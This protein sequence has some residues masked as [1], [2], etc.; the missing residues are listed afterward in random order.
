MT[1]G[2]GRGPRREADPSA[3]PAR[4]SIDGELDGVYLRDGRPLLHLSDIPP[5]G[6]E[7]KV[8]LFNSRGEAVG[9]AEGGS[10]CIHWH[11]YREETEAIRIDSERASMDRLLESPSASMAIDSISK[12]TYEEQKAVLYALQNGDAVNL[13]YASSQMAKTKMYREKTKH[14]TEV[15]MGRA[16][17]RLYNRG[18]GTVSKRSDGLI[19]LTVSRERLRAVIS[20]EAAA[21]RQ[22]GA[23]DINLMKVPCEIPTS[24]SEGASGQSAGKP[25]RKPQP[26]PSDIPRRVS[27]ERLCA[28]K[29]LTGIR[30]V[31]DAD[32][33]DIELR[34]L[35]YLDDTEDRI[36]TLLDGYTG[37]SVGFEYSTRFNDISKAAANLEKFD[38]ALKQSFRDHRRAVFLTLTTDPNL[39][40]EERTAVRD[41]RL[42]KVSA[43]LSFPAC[44]PKRRAYLAR[45][46][47]QIMG[48]DAEIEELE[49][50]KEAGT[51]TA[52]GERRLGSLLADRKHAEELRAVLADPSTGT[53]T[54]ERI[55]AALKR[56]NR[57][58]YRWD[59]KGFRSVWE[60]NRSFGRSW[61]KFMAY[62]TKK[63]GGRRP[64][65]ISAFEFTE[66]GLLHIHVLI[67]VDYLAD[68]EEISKEWRRIGQGEISYIYGLKAVRSRDGKDWEWRWN[69]KARPEDAK[70][71]SGGDYLKKY[72][73]K[74]ML[75]MMDD[76]TSPARIQSPYW[77]FNKRFNSCSRSLM[78]GF[79]EPGKDK[80]KNKNKNKTEKAKPSR[81]GI[82]RI[83]SAGEAEFLS[84]EVIYHRVTRESMAEHRA[85]DPPD[86]EQAEGDAHDQRS[87][88]Q[89]LPRHPGP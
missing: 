6:L 19:W 25:P 8:E 39:S 29:I 7:E 30:T 9:W 45:K 36:I 13:P 46:Y 82:W 58:E 48:P 49:R 32:R 22:G 64:Q 87:E 75:A 55:I 42:R 52:D 51:I 15:A 57:W 31:G 5:E 53:R 61:N 88:H 27:A 63:R 23:R 37:D 62:L 65:Y 2:S 69:A 66:S 11:R 14:A 43:E 79:G 44:S 73:R 77:A 70:G 59:P 78:K 17:R 10:T 33:S 28:I 71:M 54:K 72:V 67:F 89:G 41:A 76:Y 74:A 18:L 1:R 47:W 80:N 34:F 26:K 40:D 24:S 38:Y 68:A 4:W 35:R 60:A 16:F 84:I 21:R 85:A 12:L 81:W 3:P 50:R 86:G 56:M 83:L 20:S